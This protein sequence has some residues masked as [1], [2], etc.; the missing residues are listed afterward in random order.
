MTLED[1]FDTTSPKYQ[2][3]DL[4][5]S[6]PDSP[7]ML[8]TSAILGGALVTIG[9]IAGTDTCNTVCAYSRSTQ[10]WV[11][12]GSLPSHCVCAAGAASL[13]DGKVMLIGGASGFLVHFTSCLYDT[14]LVGLISLQLYSP[15]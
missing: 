13:P 11:E 5:Q 4:W 10:S 2:E 12:L 14:D 6:L 15:N 8:P 3:P 7:T 9:G 1:F